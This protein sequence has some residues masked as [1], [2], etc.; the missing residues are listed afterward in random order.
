MMSYVSFSAAPSAADSAKILQSLKD[1]KP[2]FAADS[3]AKF[4]LGRNSSA[5]PFFD[6]YTPKSKLQVPNKDSIIDLP[7]G[8]VYG[9]YEDA[10]D[11][12]L[13]KKIGTKM[14]PD[15]IKCRHILLGTIDPQTQQPTMDDSTAHRI[16]DS[17]D[18]AIQHGASFDS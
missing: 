2:Q 13:A 10:N 9:P 4:F 3:N 18:L 1:L 15:S 17:I 7:D 5:V 11:F 16:A 8:G 6:G 12:V 14:L